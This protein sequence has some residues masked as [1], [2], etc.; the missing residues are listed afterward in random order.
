[1]KWNDAAASITICVI[2]HHAFTL[3]LSG[4]PERE[5]LKAKFAIVGHTF[6]LIRLHQFQS[7]IHHVDKAR[8]FVLERKNL[9]DQTITRRPIEPQRLI[10]VRYRSEK[11]K[12][13]A[14]TRDWSPF[15]HQLLNAV[16]C[17][18]RQHTRD[19]DLQFRM[20]EHVLLYLLINTWSAHFA[21]RFLSAINRNYPR[22]IVP[23]RQLDCPIRDDG[24][25]FEI[26]SS[27]FD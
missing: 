2:A 13:N 6:R 1:M 7:G 16:R 10:K 14:P 5:C 4:R 23:I 12:D 9:L 24:V 26:M 8:I 15:P 18:G 20:I 21:K 3:W 11:V 22:A 25:V 27:D 19:L 17:D